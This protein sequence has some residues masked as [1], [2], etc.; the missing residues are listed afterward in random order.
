MNNTCDIYAILPSRLET[1]LDIMLRPIEHR[2]S[3]SDDEF[4]KMAVA[5]EAKASR[6]IRGSIAVLSLQGYIAQKRD[7]FLM[8]F[9][10]T[11][12]E[13]FGAAFDKALAD[14]DVS[15]VVLDVDSPG[16]SVYGVHELAT[17]IRSARGQKPIVA[18]SN[19]LMASAALWIGTAADKVYVT[20]SG[21]TGSV[22]V[23]AVHVE[24]S[25]ADAELGVKYS[26]IQSGQH[27]AEANPY[28]PLDEDARDFIQQRVDEYR[29]MFVADLAKQRGLRKDSLQKNF[30]DGRVFGAAE[31]VE[32]GI[33]DGI[34]TFEDVVKQLA[35][36][37]GVRTDTRRLR[38]A[39]AKI[40][41]DSQ[42]AA[43]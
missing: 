39:T 8:F 16:G 7:W 9:G 28:E 21:E 6:R 15:A 27:K 35:S 4:V 14:K 13:E 2:S 41:L 38:Q 25:K 22:G 5:A 10:G 29:D 26:I 3:K 34:A 23:V 33:V 1:M 19:S 37:R 43:G 17:K 24:T 12:T 32:R 42:I 20:P 11:S 18:V 30:G 36:K 40:A 31:S